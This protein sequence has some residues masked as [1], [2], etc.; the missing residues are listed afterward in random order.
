MVLFCLFD[1]FYVLVELN[2]T[3]DLLMQERES[4]NKKLLDAPVEGISLA[5]YQAMVE[6]VSVFTCVIVLIKFIGFSTSSSTCN[7]GSR[8]S[9][10]KR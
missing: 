7:Q 3:V 2:N 4:I 1:T 10:H 9:S 8:T 6:Q 5:Q